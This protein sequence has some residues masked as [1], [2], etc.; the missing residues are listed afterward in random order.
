VTIS[1]SGKLYVN[2]TLVYAQSGGIA[3]VAVDYIAAGITVSNGATVQITSGGWCSNGSL[4]LGASG[5]GGELVISG[6]W[7]LGN[8]VATGNGGTL[9][10]NSTSAQWY[11]ISQTQ[12][13]AFLKLDGN[14]QLNVSGTAVING[15]VWVGGNARLVVSAATTVTGDVTVIALGTYNV[16][17]N[18]N[19]NVSGQLTLGSDA[20]SGVNPTLWV[21]TGVSVN[22]HTVTVQSGGNVAVQANAQLWVHTVNFSAAS[23]TVSGSGSLNVT[24]FFYYSKSGGSVQVNATFSLT[25]SLQVSNGAQVQIT[26]TGW[27]D[28]SNG[29]SIALGSSGQG[30]ELEITGAWNHGN[31]IPTGGGGNLTFNSATTTNYALAQGTYAI[32]YLKATGSAQIWAVAVVS[33]NGGVWLAGTA[34]LYV[35][36]TTTVVANVTATANAII[37]VEG[38]NL[39]AA[40]V[41][42]GSSTTYILHAAT[43]I[44][45]T[46]VAT[47]EIAFS[48]TINVL[49][50]VVID[51]TENVTVA[52]Y[53]GFTGMFTNV[54]VSVAASASSD[55]HTSSRRLLS[56]T[57]SVSYG[58]TN[59]QAYKSGS[60]GASSLSPSVLLVG[61][62]VSLSALVIKV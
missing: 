60:N 42:F 56:T 48:G 15:I 33:F 20:T 50:Q 49:S 9:T 25:G 41:Q 4:S 2:G 35:N 6:A 53:T 43:A 32:A 8:C 34:R 12:T 29:G 46:V 44:P 26:G 19:L 37:E 14:A 45:P 16:A 18:A 62:L 17:V 38:A 39:H 28:A 24:G 54:D 58:P 59:A 7:S 3:I 40:A 27:C 1:G 51:A 47:G 5:S 30:G 22:V 21:G 36:Q 52:T 55:A 61:L 23:A 10:F 13:V 57:Y 31:C 11:A